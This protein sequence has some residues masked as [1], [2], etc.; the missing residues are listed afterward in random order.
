MGYQ[1][2]KSKEE[3]PDQTADLSLH[4]LSRPFEP[5]KVGCIQQLTD[6]TA[7]LSLHCL[8]RPFEPLKVGCIQQLT[9]RA[10]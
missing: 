10:A 5:L 2:Q 6:Q 4:C 3:V 1:G 7:D 9:Y 8:S